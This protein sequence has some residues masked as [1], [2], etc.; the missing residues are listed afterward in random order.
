MIDKFSNVS[1]DK[2]QEKISDIKDASIQIAQHKEKIVDDSFDVLLAK[3]SRSK[4][5]GENT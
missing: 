4:W 5:Q 1:D 2:L 3:I